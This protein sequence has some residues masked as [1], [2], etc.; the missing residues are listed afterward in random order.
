MSNQ[1]H[2]MLPTEADLHQFGERLAHLVKKGSVI[3]LDG[4][5]GAGKTTLTRGFLR[6]LGFNDKVKSPTYTL[7]EPYHLPECDVF[8]FDFYRLNEA[9]ELEHIGI[10]EYFTANAICLIEWPEKGSSY[11][12]SPD[13][14]CHIAFAEK[15]REIRLEAHSTLSQAWLEQLQKE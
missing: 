12:P 14:T 7:V 13:L 6:G 15:G 9:K 5:L 11:V 10:Q 4:P 8:H 2:I 3:F 1:F